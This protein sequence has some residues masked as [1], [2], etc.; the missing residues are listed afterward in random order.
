MDVWG[1]TQYL[2]LDPAPLLRVQ[3]LVNRVEEEFQEVESSLYLQQGQLVWSGLPLHPTRLLVHYLSTSLLPGLAERRPVSPAPHQGRFLVGG[4]DVPLPVVHV[5][6][7]RYHLVVYHAINST[8]CL[9]LHHQPATT[10]YT[11]LH[12]TVGPALA[13]LSADL[14]HIWTQKVATTPVPDQVRFLYFNSANMAVKSTA[15]GGDMV[16]LAGDLVTDLGKLDGGEGGE[17]TVKLATDQWIVARTAG[18]RTVL[19]LL[20]QRNLNLMEVEEEVTKLYK[21]SFDNICMM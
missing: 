14:T 3:S 1:G 16:R 5:G 4:S 12:E 11:R 7:R 18:A 21:T 6:E 8:L 17:V 13:N 19:V 10:L 2:P 9:V 15:Q 20:L